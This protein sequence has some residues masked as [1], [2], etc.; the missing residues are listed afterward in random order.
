VGAAETTPQSLRVEVG[1]GDPYGKGDQPLL[2][3][4]LPAGVA[5]QRAYQV[6]T[7]DGYDS[8]RVE[9]DRQ[10]YVSVPVFDR[11][12]RRTRARARVWTD[13]GESAWSSPVPLDS[14]L[15]GESDWSAV[16]VGVA[17]DV[18]PE[19][20][21]RR[22]SWVRTELELG[23]SVDACLHA[24][25]LGI[26]EVF[27][28]GRRVGDRELTPG[29]TQ[30]AK[31]V[32]CQSYDV[33]GLTPGR[34]V[35]AVLLADGWYRGQI[36][37][38][39][40]AD[41][42]GSRTAL[43]LQ[44]ES[45]DGSATPLLVTDAGWRSAPSHVLAA[46]LI[47]GQ[48]EDRRLV[49]GGLHTPGWDVSS[50]TPVDVLDERVAVVR[51]IA[52]PVRRTEELRPVSVVQRPDGSWLVDLGQNINGWARLS[53]LGP[54]G[55]RST[56]RHGEHL[57][58]A[59]DLTTRHL[60]VHFPILP[61][62]L[63][64][65]QVDEVT[66]AGRAGDTFEPRLATKGFRYVS[67][68]GHPGPLGVDDVTGIVVHSD[69][70]RTGWFE[71]SDDR[72]NRLH[73][74]VVWSLRDNVCDVPTDCPQRE[75]SPWVGD[76]QVFAS[77]A[78]YLFD[79][80]GFS[81]KFLR[82]VAIEQRADGCINNFA[83]SGAFE[84]FDGP[85]GGFH[86]SA[87]WGDAV[88]AV[89]WDLY[90]AYGD[91]TLLREA[92]GPATRWLEFA[93]GRAREG[94]HPARA[95]ARPEPA[96]HEIYL[97]DTGF[98]WGEWLEPNAEVDDF[99]AFL[100]SDKAEVATAYL[101]RSARTAAV[102][103]RL[104]G[105]DPA[106]VARW[107]EV[108]GGAKA[109]WQAEFVGADGRLAVQ[110]QA[111]HVRALAFGLVPDEL[112][113][114]VGDRLVQL[115]AEADGHLTTGF[116][117]TGL[118]LPTLAEVG[119]LETAYGLLLQD[120]EPSWL[121]M[122]DRG[123]TTVWERGNGVDADG[124]PH[125]S[126]NHYSKGAVAGFLHQ[127]VAGLRPTTPGYRTFLVDP[128]PGGGLT[129]ASAALRSPYGLIETAWRIDGASTELTVTVPPGTTAEVALPDGSRE[130]VGPGSHRRTT[131]A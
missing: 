129:S 126:L 64:L 131:P 30:Y 60:D 32:Q 35:V 93:A 82:D 18:V 69:L 104:I 21:H 79:V 49:D 2:S 122:I 54:E 13:L 1:G 34:H 90:Q 66:S 65:G 95:E 101:H 111:S 108:A 114:A 57:D 26:Y 117:S 48:H 61:E 17:E 56:L 53:D 4:E 77:T 92:W 59:G 51:E 52:P 15:L 94:R 16:W 121:T 29:Y 86:G 75:R 62:P 87:G 33:P 71:C 130:R 128:R 70:R 22:P 76:W 91:D 109:A 11:S 19:K 6:V 25:A 103:G 116:L 97:W 8:G 124:V 37:A 40:A 5:L 85:L 20:G 84:G 3:W 89:P 83:P 67:V 63:P 98:H 127:W 38:P 106:L 39:R 55:T 80:D 112:R 42:Y 43:R 120:T 102:V 96:P 50:W 81:R 9:S 12:R 110:T 27:L 31:R 118:L 45:A 58:E 78:A 36:G 125:E 41:Q 113:V 44:L 46:D 107:E 119:H 68:E 7:E 14:G 115:V 74:A 10:S 28:D 105:A 47:G 23:E 123:A 24:T 73:E 72:L 100:A 88:I 99:P